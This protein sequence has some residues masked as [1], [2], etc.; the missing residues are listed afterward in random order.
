LVTITE[1]CY[2]I[3]DM[4]MDYGGARDPADLVR[5]SDELTPYDPQQGLSEHYAG[6]FIA[7]WL[8]WAHL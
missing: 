6:Q 5:W 3:N 1:E 2:S 7:I 8:R 4:M